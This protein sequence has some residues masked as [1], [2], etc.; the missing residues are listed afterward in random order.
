[1]G[2]RFSKLHTERKSIESF[3]ISEIDDFETNFAI[4]ESSGF[5]VWL[6]GKAR[7]PLFNCGILFRVKSHDF[8]Y[9]RRC[10]EYVESITADNLKE[11]TALYKCFEALAGYVADMLEE[12]SGEFDLGGILVDKYSTV[13]DLIKLIAPAALTF[14]RHDLLSEEESPV[15]FSLKLY[16]KPVPDEF[17]EIALHG[18]E[19]IYAGEYR[20]VSPWNEK[21]PKKEYNY[22]RYL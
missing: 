6:E 20:G 12:H 11:C 15:A 4:C 9:A 1:M 8:V 5:F 22:V 10:A 17:M 2:N 18:N 21:L 3:G 19:P 13:E 16:F 14:E 7:F